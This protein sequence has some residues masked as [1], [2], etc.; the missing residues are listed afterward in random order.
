MDKNNTKTED[1]Q[2][3]LAS[4]WSRLWASIIDTMIFG[5]CMALIIYFTNG[6]EL[7]N[8]E[9]ITK[10]STPYWVIIELLN[11]L[12]FMGINYKFLI[13][14]GQTIGKIILKIKIVDLNNELPTKSSLL[15]RYSFYFLPPYIPVIGGIIST[16]N[17]L[18]IFGKEKRCIHDII[19]KTRVINIKV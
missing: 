15:K 9:M 4:R 14:N 6:I 5:I 16:L 1:I 10:E 3:V 12:L 17:I 11:L 13:N 7:V 18:F 8:G 19:A 2:E